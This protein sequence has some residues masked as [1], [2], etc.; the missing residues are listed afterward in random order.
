MIQEVNVFLWGTNIGKLTWDAERHLAMFQFS[1]AYMSQPYDLCPLTHKKVGRNIA[2]FLGNPKDLYQGL[3]EFI[4]DALPD[5]WGSTLFDKWVS[6]KSVPISEVTPLLKLSY[7]GKRAMG[8]LEFVP[9][10]DKDDFSGNV[11]M[12]SLADL[13]AKVYR[14][15]EAALI[16]KEESLTI[17]KLI[18]LGTSA[19]GKRPKA[20]VAYNPETGEFRSGQID[21]PEGFMQYIVKFK[22]EKDSPTTEIE[23]IWYEMAKD[24]GITMMPCFLKN[25]DGQNHFFTER[26]DRVGGEK[27]MTQT[28]AAIL[29]GADDYMKFV[30][31]ADSLGLPQE[32]KDQLF[33]RMV[34]NFAA[35]IS[36]DHNK[37][38][39]FM[40][41]REGHWRL[42]P[43]YDVMFTANI[44][45]DPSSYVHS[46][47]VMGK[48][49]ALK[50][51]D[52][53]GF[54]ADFVDDAE[55]KISRVLAA[56]DKFDT[57]CDNYAIDLDVRSKIRSA[58]EFVRP[59]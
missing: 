10:T 46:L 8:A 14:D 37:N 21:L 12:G 49:S 45:E 25:I 48:K 31:L 22:E 28:L 2:P 30:W 53:K 19:G 16:S 36:D 41:D 32:D 6:D 18:Y 27:I 34:F 43:A 52:F 50:I 24:A 20:V 13:A 1:E 51:A 29:P 35:G 5:A 55:G 4:A 40:M 54:A 26:F 59:R 42:A 23:M 56:V 11:D 58:L 9:E 44:W 39:S 15:R 3:P 33:I 17:K 57:W 7:I 38:F 47:G